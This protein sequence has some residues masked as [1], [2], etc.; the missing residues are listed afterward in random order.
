LVN[1]VI[2][3]LPLELCAGGSDFGD[4][5]ASGELGCAGPAFWPLDEPVLVCV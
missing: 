4:D 1:D 2:D 5:V 3:S